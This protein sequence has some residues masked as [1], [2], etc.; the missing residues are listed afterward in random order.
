M[1]TS[2][3][4]SDIPWKFLSNISEMLNVICCDLGVLLWL[5]FFQMEEQKDLET[6]SFLTCY[7]S[8]KVKVKMYFALSG[9]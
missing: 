4:K 5:H 9:K 1:S 8:L 3:G 7:S 2:Q 6:K